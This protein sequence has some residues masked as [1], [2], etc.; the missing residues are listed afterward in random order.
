M[1]RVSSRNFFHENRAKIA[2]RF[3]QVSSKN[4]TKFW[5]FCPLMRKSYFGQILEEILVFKHFVIS[6]YFV[7]L[8]YLVISLNFEKQFLNSRK[9]WRNSK[10]YSSPLGPHTCRSNWPQFSGFRSPNHTFLT[11]EINPK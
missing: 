3:T 5:C 1:F 4:C 9:W 6:Y 2:Q 10:L 11:P 8:S 7:I